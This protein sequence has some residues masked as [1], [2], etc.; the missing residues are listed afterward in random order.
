MNKTNETYKSQFIV[1]RNFMNSNYKIKVRVKCGFEDAWYPALNIIN[2]DGNLKWRERFFT[3]LHEAGHALCDI[4]DNV[5]K[6]KVCFAK[7]NP[8]KCNS[9][10]SFV[11]TI[12]NEIMAWNKGKEISEMMNFSLNEEDYES[13]MTRCIMS[14]VKYGLKEVYGKE[15]N[16]DSIKP[17]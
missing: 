10:K 4:A 16:I 12:N 8:Q 2:I 9:K 3:L 7:S 14:H 1:L 17:C 13:Y 11:H 6:S 15:I 5:E